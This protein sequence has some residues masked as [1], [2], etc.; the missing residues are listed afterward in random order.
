MKLFDLY[1]KV[2]TDKEVVIRNEY[3]RELF[4]GKF[5][6]VSMRCGYFMVCKVTEEDDIIVIYI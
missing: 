4:K 2:K 1:Y 3:E 5:G 6:D